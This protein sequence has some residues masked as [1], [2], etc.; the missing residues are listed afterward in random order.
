MYGAW[1]RNGTHHPLSDPGFGS[2]V[3]AGRLLTSAGL[4]EDQALFGT[5]A[6]SI[7][8]ISRSAPGRHRLRRDLAWDTTRS[9]AFAAALPSG[10]DSPRRGSNQPAGAMDLRYR[11]DVRALRVRMRRGRSLYLAVMLSSADCGDLLHPG[12]DVLSAPE[13]LATRAGALKLISP[14]HVGPT[15]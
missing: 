10:S 5:P 15:R 9:F 8:R 6:Q 4:N 13:R 1:R 12:A 2:P 3:A 11:V 14:D 7:M